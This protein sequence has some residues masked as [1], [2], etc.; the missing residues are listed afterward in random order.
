MGVGV[1]KKEITDSNGP[2]RAYWTPEYYLTVMSIFLCTGTFLK[3]GATG[4][5]PAIITIYPYHKLTWGGSYSNGYPCVHGGKIHWGMETPNRSDSE[6][7]HQSGHH[8]HIQTVG[9]CT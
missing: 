5:A 4:G 1:N 3:R 9:I 7:V 6:H 8:E 2:L